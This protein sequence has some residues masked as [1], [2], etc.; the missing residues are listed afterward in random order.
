VHS[1]NAGP[2]GVVTAGGEIDLATAP[3]IREAISDL[4]AA[5][6]THLVLDLREVTFMDSTGLGILV[7]AGKRASGLGGALRVVCDN[8]RVLRLL[9]MTGLSRS[10]AVHPTLE[11]ATADWSRG[12]S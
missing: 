6:H 10:L 1:S 9:A 7:G 2:A 3:G 8:A 4:M 12:S 5:G 11:D